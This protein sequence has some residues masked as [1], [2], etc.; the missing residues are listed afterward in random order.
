MGLRPRGSCCRLR[1][2]AQGADWQ[3]KGQERGLTKSYWF[4][5]HGRKP[6][7]SREGGDT[8]SFGGW[9]LY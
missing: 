3:L 7:T 4:N 5:M 6:G 2:P 9:G 1:L 8:E